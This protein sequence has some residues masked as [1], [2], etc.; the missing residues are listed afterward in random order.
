MLRDVVIG[1]G[2]GVEGCC[3][4]SPA[5]QV[6]EG[7]GLGHWTGDRAVDQVAGGA[8]AKMPCR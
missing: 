5:G 4:A 2:A 7:E 1:L 6:E 8:R 3:E